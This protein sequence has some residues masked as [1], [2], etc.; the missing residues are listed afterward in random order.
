MNSPS[1]GA[2][3]LFL[4]IFTVL[5]AWIVLVP[6]YQAWRWGE[7][8][9]R[10]PAARGRI[11]YAGTLFIPRPNGSGGTHL[12]WVVCEYSI[13]GKR[14]KCRRIEFGFR[15]GTSRELA[16]QSVSQFRTGSESVVYCNPSNPGL[17]VLKPGLPAGRLRF[18]LLYSALLLCVAAAGGIWVVLQASG[19]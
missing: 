14:Y 6:T 7:K 15:F 4:L 16:E 10:W 3:L 9:R 17:A 19:Q 13:G 18:N 2:I 5:A 11:L 12:P 1:T 8:S